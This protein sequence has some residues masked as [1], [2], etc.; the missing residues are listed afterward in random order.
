[1]NACGAAEDETPGPVRVSRGQEVPR[2]CYVHLLEV[3][4]I[5]GFPECR[6]EMTDALR[7]G[8]GAHE[9]VA[10]QEVTLTDNDP[11]T[12]SARK[13]IAGRAL[14]SAQCDDVMPRRR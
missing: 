5:G 13:R 10:I 7:T 2:A 6:S 9:R 8:R 11:G 3:R 4:L 14:V 12:F 1:M